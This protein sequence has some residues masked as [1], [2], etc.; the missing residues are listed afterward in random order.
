M[1]RQTLPRL[2]NGEG[3]NG[4]RAPHQHSITSLFKKAA[5]AAAINSSSKAGAEGAGAQGKGAV[6][7]AAEAPRMSAQLQSAPSAREHS[8]VTGRIGRA[9][10]AID[11]PS[12]SR[13]GH[14]EERGSNAAHADPPAQVGSEGAERRP[15]SGSGPLGSPPHLQ[16]HLH[17][18]SVR[19]QATVGRILERASPQKPSG[20]AAP[21]QAAD[22][23]GQQPCTSAPSHAG[24]PEAEPA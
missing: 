3:T 6:S 19:Q 1:G 16:G 23:A 8:A 22:A 20:S 18:D 2:E 17:T 5:A 13:G 11:A 9:P 7:T 21:R 14:P 4:S 15:S 12:G 10:G 24:L